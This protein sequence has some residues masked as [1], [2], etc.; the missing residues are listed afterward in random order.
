VEGCTTLRAKG[1]ALY[2]LKE[3]DLKKALRTIIPPQ[4]ALELAMIVIVY[5]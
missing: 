4:R 5:R 1:S 3:D 2:S